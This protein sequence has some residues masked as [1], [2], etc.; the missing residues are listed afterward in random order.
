MNQAALFEEMIET[1]NGHGAVTISVELGRDGAIEVSF[2]GRDA[3]TETYQCND[4]A[5]VVAIGIAL[6]R[7]AETARAAAGT[8]SG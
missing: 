3:P 2:R 5:E 4:P 6:I 8:E 7:A 1:H